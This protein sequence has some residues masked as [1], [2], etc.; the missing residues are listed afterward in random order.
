MPAHKK[1][2]RNFKWT[3]ELG[4]VVGLLTADGSLSK[5]GRHIILASTD[6]GLLKLANK[7][8]NFKNKITKNPRSNKTKKQGWRVQFGNVQLYRW[9]EKIRLTPDKTHTL[10]G[11][12][13]PKEVFRDFIRGHIDGDGSIIS[14]IDKYNTSK[15]PKYVYKRLIT[16]LIAHRIEHLIWIRKNLKT[17]IGINGCLMDKFKTNGA[18]ISK[19]SKKE[20]IKLLHWIYYSPEVPC[21]KRKYDKA[22]EFLSQ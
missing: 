14:Y 2:D 17:I 20:S 13:I 18:W 16:Y 15:N 19:Y 5:D 6:K 12:K 7:I 4:Y 1:P 8:L 11:L 22:K 3:P 10:S 9:L 21:L